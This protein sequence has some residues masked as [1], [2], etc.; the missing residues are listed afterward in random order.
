[1]AVGKLD[2]MD[3]APSENGNPQGEGEGGGGG[4]ETSGA[5]ALYA[6][7]PKIPDDLRED[8]FSAV[9]VAHFVVDKDG[10]VQVTL[11]KPTSN[12]ALNQIILDTLRTWRF[13]PAVK[14]GVPVA[15]EFD[16]RIPI[17][18]Q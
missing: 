10:N 17:A 9:A 7:V 13:F 6:P 5:S 8:A 12:P 3:R 15:S 18:V 4:P 14:D 16:V 2:S 1:M 11:S